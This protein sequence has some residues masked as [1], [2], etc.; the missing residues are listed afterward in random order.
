MSPFILNYILICILFYLIGSIPTAYL[1]VR[2][3]NIDITQAGSGN[4]GALNSYDVTKSKTIGILVLVLDF[5]KGFIPALL[6]TRFFLLPFSYAILPL[7]LLVVG[8]NFSVWLKFKGGRGLATSAGISLAVN[9][10]LLIIWCTVFFIV[11]AVRRN[12][13]FANIAA[14][15]FMPLVVIFTSDLI[16]KFNYDYGLN[17]GDVNFNLNLLFTLTSVISILILIRHIKPLMDMIR[18]MKN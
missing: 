10:W 13:H 1:L 3:K 6:L 14:T 17:N 18:N 9:F 11:Y 5:L 15:V 8:H 12:I 7:I 2:N 4:V 16:V